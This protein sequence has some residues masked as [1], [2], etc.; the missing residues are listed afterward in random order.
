MG[1]FESYAVIVVFRRIKNFG[2]LVT[3]G[4]QKMK[5]PFINVGTW[6]VWLRKRKLK[7]ILCLEWETFGIVRGVDK[8]IIVITQLP[9]VRL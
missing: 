9:D 5:L 3:T 2:Q 8:K 7:P 1:M 6:A 4:K